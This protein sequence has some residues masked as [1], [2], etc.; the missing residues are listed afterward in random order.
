MHETK[1]R[2][3]RIQACDGSGRRARSFNDEGAGNRGQP[4]PHIGD[5]IGARQGVRALRQGNGI[6]LP[7]RVRRIDGIDDTRH[8][9]GWTRE[10]RCLAR[11]PEHEDAEECENPYTAS[12]RWESESEAAESLDRCVAH[13]K[14]SQQS[15]GS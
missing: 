3:S 10:V 5:V 2:R 14:P 15:G 13:A 6:R 7:V 4:I 11:T 9:A 8:I 12:H 1:S